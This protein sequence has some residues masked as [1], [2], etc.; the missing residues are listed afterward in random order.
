MAQNKLENQIRE[1][2]NAREI[3]PS[4]QAWDRLD[5]MLTVTEEKKTKRFPFWF[6]GVAA[7][8]LVFLTVGLFFFNQ[9]ETILIPNNEIVVA[10]ENQKSAIDNEK[11]ILEE[12][13]VVSSDNQSEKINQK[14][15]IK[16]KGVSINNQKAN[17]SSI[18]N[19]EKE[20]E[21][22]VAGNVAAVKD[23][24]KVTSNEPIIVQPKKE[25]TS[26]KSAY[27]D[28]DALLASAEK[29]SN[30][31]QKTDMINVDANILLSHA[32]K[33][34]ESTFRE[35]VINKISK[36]YQEVKSALANRNQE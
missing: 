4:A 30:A 13:Q 36:N 28:V 12:N 3:Q 26:K 7:S 14:Q 31:N 24:P 22:L 9:G 27:V 20:I 16:N 15:L 6:I 25:I 19:H 2:L 21:Y 17:Q 29:Q 35:R 11:L 10:P 1:K 8:V 33:E 32:D 5:A 18:I 23:V 34:V